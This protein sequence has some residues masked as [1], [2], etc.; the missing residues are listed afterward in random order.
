MAGE[1]NISQVEGTEQEREV[2]NVVMVCFI[3]TLKKCACILR[4]KRH[5]N[6]AKY[7]KV[8]VGNDQEKAQSER[9]SI[10]KNRG[11]K[12]GINN[13]ALILLKHIVSRMSSYFLNRWPLSYLNLTKH[14][15][16]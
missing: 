11:G 12:K 7:K 4:K 6:N 15:K 14:M 3:Y 13:Q 9:K 10:S 1:H 8:Q 2:S 5:G 16:T